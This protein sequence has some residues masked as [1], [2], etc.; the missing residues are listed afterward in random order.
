MAVRTTALLWLAAGCLLSLGCSVDEVPDG[1]KRTPSG[2]ANTVR[3]DLY[4]KPLPE[5]PLPNDVAMW[6]DPTSRTGLRVNAS[7][8]APTNIEQTA[9]EKFDTLEGWGT[10]SALTVA[11]DRRDESDPRPAIDL[12]NIIRRHQ[13]DDYELEDDGIYLVNLETGIPAVLDIGEGSFQYVIR[14]KHKYWRNDT[15]RYEQNLLYD[16]ADEAIDPAT[17]LFDD[18]RTTYQPSYDT[19]FDG[20]LDRPNLLDPTGAPGNFGSCASQVEIQQCYANGDPNC[21]ELEVARDQCVT[22]QLLGWYERETDTLIMRPLV[23]LMEKTRYAVVVTDRV[24]DYDGRAVKSP[25]DYVYHPSQ[26][27]A[28]KQLKKHLENPELAAY[29]GDVGGSGLDHVAFT[30]TFT[31]QPVVEDLVLIRDGLYGKGPFAHLA[32]EIPDEPTMARAA[33]RLTKQQIEDGTVEEPDW[34]DNRFCEGRRERFH[35]VDLDLVQGILSDLAEQAF[36]LEGPELE[37]LT[38][39]FNEIDH[40]AIGSVKTPFFIAGGPKGEDPNASIELD[41]KDGEGNMAVDEVQFM[42]AVPKARPGHSQPFPVAMYGH[43]YTSALVEHLGFAGDLARQGI[44]SVGWNAV[45]HG[46]D[47][48]EA[49]KQLA[50]AL[51]IVGC[52]APF[53]DALL[54]GRQRDLDEDG[55]LDSGG[56]YWTSYLF[57]T[58]DVVRQSAIDSLQLFRVFKQFGTR[59]ANQDYDQDGNMDELLGD[60]DNDGTPDFGGPDVEYYTWG[61]SLGGIL[62]P[63]AAALDPDV[64][65]S[66]PTSGSGGLLDVGVRTFQ[67]GAFEGIYLRNFGPIIAGVPADQLG[68]DT[69]CSPEQVSLRFVV[70]NVNED[71]EVE[72]HCLDRNETA[73]AD[74]GTVV[75][76]NLDNGEV[77]CGRVD[78][79]G[80]FRIGLPS[81]VGDRIEV[82]LYDKPDVIDTYDWEVGCNVTDGAN[83]IALVNTFGDGIVPKGFV[84]PKSNEIGCDHEGGCAKFQDKYYPKGATLVAI[85]EGFGHIR[86]TPSLRRFMNLA[87][88][89]VDPGDPINMAPHFALRPLMD[90]NGNPHPSTGLANIVTIG[91]MNVPLNSGI[92]MARAAGALPFLRPDAVDRYPALADYVTPVELYDQLGGKTPNRVLIDQHVMEGINRLRRHPPDSCTPNEVPIT[93]DNIDCHPNCTDDSDCLGG[94]MCN[95]DGRCERRPIS[96]NDCQ[97]YLYDIDAFDEGQALHGEEEAAVPLRVARIATAATPGTI[98]DVWAPRLLGAPYS[99]NQGA[100]MADK[101]IVASLKGYIIPKGE[102][103]FFI[104]NRCD[105]F[106]IDAYLI[107]TVGRFFSSSGSDLF[108]LSHPATHHCMAAPQPGDDCSFIQRVPPPAE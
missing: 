59:T 108:Y 57:H 50:Q 8:V 89:V 62:A 65:A 68:D 23:P 3:F 29:Y 31:T 98:D 25:F 17:G 12:E 82:Q 28:V 106:S 53:G 24:V 7:V 43:G 4:H 75:V 83:R 18:K 86:Q 102:H 13:G 81:T 92:A 19:D 88:N 27:T 84:D 39:G 33:G 90:W 5:V 11:F 87:G 30:W 44:A 97:Q 67:G 42:V 96:D 15:R 64:V 72:F 103:G 49:E 76:N 100:W 48:P 52:Q 10:F 37:H 73:G 94:Q 77:R 26:I 32:S 21:A 14:E 61:Q 85:A 38:S 56:D 80:V 107:N 58:R 79:Q 70:L 104:G 71:V 95:G 74:G 91:D 41:F 60:F 101:R 2:P 34:D 40:L 1:L 9:R 54:T 93:P 66:A 20:V 46:Q 99:S 6:P 63:F 22:D 36:G 78:P 51:F 47:L 16:T 69:V 105:N 45:Y 35:I 55:L